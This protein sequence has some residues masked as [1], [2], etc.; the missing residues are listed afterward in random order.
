MSK[1]YL[2][3]LAFGVAF[4]GSVS[5]WATKKPPRE[6]NGIRVVDSAQISIYV[7]GKE[8]RPYAQTGFQLNIY[9]ASVVVKQT[10][11]HGRQIIRSRL[12]SIDADLLELGMWQ[13]GDFNGDGLDDFRVVAQIGKTGCRVWST[14][15]WL[16]DRERFTFSEKIEYRTD[17]DGKPVK[18]CR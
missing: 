13:V 4:L 10:Q 3:A 15:T 1:P 8:S 17:A 2:F 11:K 14:Q 18:S 12:E 7:V 9:E 16:P 5:A 6:P